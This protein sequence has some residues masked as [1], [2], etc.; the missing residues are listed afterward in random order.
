MKI[1]F[2]KVAYFF[3]KTLGNNPLVTWVFEDNEKIVEETRKRKVE[4]LCL[5]T[6][7]NGD[8]NS[9]TKNI[10]RKKLIYLEYD[11]LRTIH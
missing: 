3:K 10:L 4:K 8:P 5:A 6:S 2:R 11:T 7:K 1:Y 9:R